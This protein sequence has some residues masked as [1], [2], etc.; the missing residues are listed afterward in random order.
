VKV[1]L[2]G[3]DHFYE[4]LRPQQG[5]QYFV[6]GG[7]AKLRA[8]NARRTEI[9]A[10]AFDRDNSFLL[11]EIEGDTLRFQAV[12]RTGETVDKGEIRR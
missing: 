12:S 10:K 8:G 9:S 6:V 2:A 4:R 3:H 5:V 1:V 11:L 7:A